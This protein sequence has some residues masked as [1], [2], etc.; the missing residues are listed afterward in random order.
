M[1]LAAKLNATKTLNNRALNLHCDPFSVEL[2]CPRPATEARRNTVSIAP[3]SN[4][5]T[6]PN[7]AGWASNCTFPCCCWLSG[8]SATSA[9]HR[10]LLIRTPLYDAKF[11]S[12]GAEAISWI[13]KNKDTGRE[14]HSVAGTKNARIPLELVSSKGLERVPREAPL[15]LA[16]GD[17]AVDNLLAS[18]NYTIEGV[19]SGA[20][21]TEL[22]LGADEKKR[23]SFLL[24]DNATGL[25]VVKTIVP[26]L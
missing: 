16:T 15:Q 23:I 19:D 12:R 2:P 7:A 21:D 5:A 9:P 25:D 14:I 17:A 13:I 18:A 4:S 10:T 6:D 11:D 24:R 1:I 3:G 8:A 26:R 22:T 20:G